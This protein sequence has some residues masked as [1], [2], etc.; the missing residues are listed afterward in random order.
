M[1]SDFLISAMM[2]R[3]KERHDMRSSGAFRRREI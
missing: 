3:D 2:A 1:L